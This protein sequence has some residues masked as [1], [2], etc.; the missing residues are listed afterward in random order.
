MPDS[1]EAAPRGPGIAYRAAFI[2][3]TPLILSHLCW[4]AWKDGGLN[5]LTERLGFYKASG[6]PQGTSGQCKQR[7]V[8]IH[9]ASVGEINTVKPLLH[10]LIHLHPDIQFTVT[11]ATPTGKVALETASLP[12]TQH[13]YLPLDYRFAVKRFYRTVSPHCGLI[14]ET[15]LWPLLYQQA[16]MP[17]ILINAR[18]SEKTKKAA[19]GWLNTAYRFCASRLTLTVAR[20]QSD[21]AAF[22]HLGATAIAQAGNLKHAITGQGS[23]DPLSLEHPFEHQRDFAL[24]ASTHDDEECQLVRLWME[25]DAPPLLVIAPRHP[26]RA[27][28]IK[29]QLNQFTTSI[30]QRS[31][32]ETPDEDT[33]VYIADT[34]GEMDLWYHNAAAIFLG[35]SLVNIGGHNML[36]P[37]R[38]KRSVIT[39]PYV[40]NFAE[41]VSALQANDGITVSNDADSVVAQLSNQYQNTETTRAQGQRAFDTVRQHEA[42]LPEYI[43]LIEPFLAEKNKENP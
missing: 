37:A 39:G 28:Q 12:N 21:A 36:E 3:A 14:V 33:A 7:S 22:D 43:R 20:H 32:G 34:F 27:E 19:S 10:Q 8:W 5:Y 23:L 31:K 17:L 41:E 4:R 38:L 29:R 1:L 16:T 40:Y 13:R 11:T 42:V 2:L 6:K 35:G 18:L 30:R 9:A 24:L 25:H 26:D 15:E